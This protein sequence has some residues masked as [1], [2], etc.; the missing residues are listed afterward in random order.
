MIADDLSVA[1]SPFSFME[2]PLHDAAE[3][4][5]YRVGVEARLADL[6]RKSGSSVTVDAYKEAIFTR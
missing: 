2:S 6:L 4:A 5:K 1:H 3:I